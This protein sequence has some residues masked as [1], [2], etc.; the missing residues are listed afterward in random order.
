MMNG[1]FVWTHDVQGIMLS[2]YYWGYLMSMF[3]GSQIAE[4]V[5]A[6]WVF[7]FAVAINVVCTMAT[8]IS[9]YTHYSL[10]YI[11]RILQGIGGGVTFPTTHVLLAHWAPPIERSIMGSIAFSGTLL[12]TVLSNLL[13]GVIAIELGWEWIFYIMGTLSSIWLLLW[14]FLVTSRPR[15]AK[16][17]SQKELDM[18]EESLGEKPS[19]DGEV[20]KKKRRKVPWLSIA[21]SLPFWAILVAHT[22]SNWAFYMLLVN[23]PI[24]MKQVLKFDM[25]EVTLFSSIPYFTMWLACI[26]IGQTMDMLRKRKKLTTTWARKIATL[27]ASVP[28]ACCLFVLCLIRCQKMVA[29]ILLTVA[30]TALGAMYSGFMTNH[31]DIANNY[32]GTLMGLTNTIGTIPG[33]VGPLFV[34]AMTN[35]DPSLASWRIIFYVTIIIVII[36]II[37]FT[38]FGTGEE[39]PWN[40]QEQAQ[41]PQTT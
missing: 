26:C 32:A 41:Q 19:A 27:I 11:M 35:I 20:K 5:S 4:I 2:A 8:P 3:P 24:F 18:I 33:I 25:S 39:Q 14:G 16:L 36:E 37:A 34:G 12:G 6:K 21:R 23:M 15:G 30:L 29:V 1:P 7:F 17:I 31:I 28:V 22:G 13:C 38:T 9:C 40:K 10:V